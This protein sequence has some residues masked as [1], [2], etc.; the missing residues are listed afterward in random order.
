MKKL[1][2]LFLF[3][4]VLASVPC[5]A[6]IDAGAGLLNS[7]AVKDLRLHE[8]VSRTK[9]KD[10]LQAKRISEQEK[11]E[12]QNVEQPLS[13]IK[14][15]SFVNNFSIPS[16]ELFNVIRSFVNKPMNSENVS[17]IRKEIMKYYQ[18][19]G[20][21][22]AVAMVVSE[23]VQTGELVLDVKEGGKNSIIIQTDN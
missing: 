12:V 20:Y 2:V 18:T 8:V 13:D 19:K 14:Y 23:D 17:A 1:S 7:D 9:G 10:T 3:I 16:E 21:Y 11:K 4:F 6:F 5:F 22:S 15:V